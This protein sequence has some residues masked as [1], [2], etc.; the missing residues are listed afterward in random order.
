MEEPDLICVGNGSQVLEQAGEFFF[1]G[2]GRENNGS[3]RC[4]HANP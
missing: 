2:G 3:Q 4:S 1:V